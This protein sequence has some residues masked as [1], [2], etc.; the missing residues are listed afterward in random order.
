[1]SARRAEGRARLLAAGLALPA[2]LVLAAGC[3]D[4]TF[5]T[6]PEARA[7]AKAAVE[8]WLAACAKEDGEAVNELLPPSV[9]EEVFKAPSV[10]DACERIADLTPA[11]EPTAEELET[12]FKEAKVERV[13]ADAGFGT[14]TVR[15]PEGRTSELELEIDRGRWHLSNPPLASR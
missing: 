14:A 15:G 11:P 8:T 5:E 13:E 1:V 4:T 10:L 2:A 6:S 12:A 3:G 7:H 9:G